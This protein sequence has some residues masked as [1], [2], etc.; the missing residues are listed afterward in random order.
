MSEDRFEG[1][2]TAELDIR[3][4]VVLW[5][6]AWPAVSL[7]LLQTVNAL[8]DT[9]FIQTLPT[10]NATAASG[11]TTSIFLFISLAFALGMASTALVARFFG[12]GN[13]PDLK[14]AC[15][16]GASTALIGG[17]SVGFLALA[18]S[19]VLAWLQIP[20][21]D[22]EAVT[23]MKT[24]LV[25][26][27]A[28]LPA[29]FLI[30]SLAG[31]LRGVGDTKSPMLLSGFQILVHIG[32]NAW[33]IPHGHGHL[34]WGIAGAGAAFAI[35]AWL[36]A[37]VYL[38]FARRTPV[39]QVRLRLPE[40]EWVRRIVRI[41]FPAAIG[42]FVRVTSLMAFTF[43]L[44]GV[45][46]ASY[47][48][49]ALR[50]SFSVESLAFMPTFGL[51]IAAA[52]LVGQCLGA[53]KPERAERVGW[54]AAHYAGAVSLVASVL[55]FSFALP[56]AHLLLPDQP[57]IAAEVATFLRYLCATEVLFAYAMVLLG[58]VQG[59]G[60]TTSP[61]WV[62]LVCMWGLRVPIAAVLAMPFGLGLGARGC[63]IS[64]MTTQAIQGVYAIWVYRRGR[65]KAKEV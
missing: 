31:S 53:K 37:I 58:A 6:L 24:Y 26:L 40:M 52:A 22:T 18:L 16:Q 14:A 5:R 65:W 47:A 36:A 4:G 2:P 27:A 34:G 9:F 20:A 7:N 35:S 48:V 63:W 44:K 61:L 54:L 45:P 33:M 62:N 60:D 50:P 13:F 55:I 38:V 39:G 56:L 30:Q 10:S 59:A 49:A 46:R 42:A 32:L 28:G 3:P 17:F 8:L 64:M 12:A 25:G 57:E 19:P 51:S 43:I 23:L 11:A 41:A 1:D 29:V 21:T 15:D